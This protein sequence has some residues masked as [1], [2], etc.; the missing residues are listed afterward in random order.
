MRRWLAR[1]GAT[2]ALATVTLLLSSCQPP[3]FDLVPALVGGRL[4]LR[5]VDPTHWPGAWNMKGVD[6]TEVTLSTRKE[7][8]WMTRLHD[9]EGACERLPELAPF[10]LTYG[11]TPACFRDKVAAKPLPQGEWIRVSSWGSRSSDGFIRITGDMVERREWRD[12]Y[13][14][15]ESWNHP[16]QRDPM[17]LGNEAASIENLH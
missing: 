9:I 3:S 14:P 5:P 17:N 16:D 1:H 6:A 4:V 7:T 13:A 11:Q 10:P 2:A 15:N 8:L 12:E